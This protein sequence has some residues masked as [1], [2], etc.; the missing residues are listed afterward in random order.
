[1]DCFQGSDFSPEVFGLITEI[2]GEA[3]IVDGQALDVGDAVRLDTMLAVQEASIVVLQSLA[4]DVF[5]LVGERRY[6]IESLEDNDELSVFAESL[7]ADQIEIIKLAALNGEALSKWDELLA[8]N[9]NSAVFKGVRYEFTA[10]QVLPLSSGDTQTQSIKIDW[11]ESDFSEK[12]SFEKSL[13]PLLQF[14]QNT[15]YDDFLNKV[16][17]GSSINLE[18]LLPFNAQLGA[19]LNVNG[20]VMIIDEGDLVAGRVMVDLPMN[21]GMLSVTATITNPGAGV[22]DASSPMEIMVDTIRPDAAINSLGIKTEASHTVEGVG[23]PGSLVS[24]YDAA[25]NF[26][27]TVLVDSNGSWSITIPYPT[28]DGSYG[29]SLISEDPAGN[30][31]EVNQL[32]SFNSE[33]PGTSSQNS[34][35][36]FI[37][38]GDGVL[39]AEEARS[40]S[41]A[42]TL[43][44]SSE[45][46]SFSVSDGINTINVALSEIFIVGG[47]INVEGIDLSSLNDGVLQAKI[48]VID[49][50]GE[51]QSYFDSAE[52]DTEVSGGDGGDNGDSSDGLTIEISDI[53][54]DSGQPGD[55][56]TTD[57][58]LVISGTLSAALQAD[59]FVEVSTDGG[60][61]WNLASLDAQVWSFDDRSNIKGLGEFI[62]IARVV[63]L[64]GNIGA[65]DSQ[66]V[67]IISASEPEP[68][69][70]PDTNNIVIAGI[71][72]DTGT[73]G[74]FR[75]IDTTLSVFGSL[76]KALQDDERIEISLDGN[77]WSEVA[78][79]GTTW[80]YEDVTV[81]DVGTVNYQVRIINDAQ[82]IIATDNQTISV[83]DEADG[84]SG[85]VNRYINFVDGGD[86]FLNQSEIT[87]VTFSGKVDA[88]DVVNSIVVSDIN[89]SRYSINFDDIT[90]TVT[91]SVN[92]S[93]QDLSSL[94]DGPLTVIMNVSDDV[95]RSGDISDTSQKDTDVG[96]GPAPAVTDNS[97]TITAISEDTGTAGDFITTDNTLTVSGTLGAA[98]QADE[99]VQIQLENGD[100]HDVLVTGTAWSFVDT[101]AHVPGSLSYSVRIIDNAQNIGATD[102]Q[103]VSIL[104]PG[105]GPGGSP[106][107]YINFIDGGDHFLNQSEV[108]TVTFTGKL[109]T[110]DTVNSIVITDI[111]NNSHNVN[112]ADISIAA[113]GSFSVN[114]QDLSQLDDGLL[115]VT[116]NL[117]DEVGRSGDV[118]DS[119]EK[120]TDVGGGPVP[121]VSNNSILITGISEDTG[122]AGGLYH[123]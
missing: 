4:G 27:D 13:A 93:A 71:S 69:P 72:D 34:T 94:A 82:S 8:E 29:F 48:T 47:V 98:L 57:T 103:D 75:T 68:D 76:T 56:I 112:L 40:T 25:G 54:D 88:T 50:K 118:N 60:L 45:L 86:Q 100:W 99:K 123:H 38:G 26:I 89:G 33:D 41:F 121:A 21:E 96:G 10:D 59:E 1:M 64:A 28:S 117:S 49:E 53:S 65:V 67:S 106:D 5:F 24:L 109:N 6:V 43:G 19:E 120:D 77:R 102:S 63:D 115:T 20:T 101:S 23:E 111:N 58:S 18:V 7:T 91:G 81:H 90:V 113:D 110:T 16:E 55:F 74:D 37:D 104:D 35:I 79:T 83:L 108:T 46:I 12:S 84:P 95:G 44:A 36:R 11:N 66:R 22:S 116:M 70:T 97:I 92:V 114:A 78:V 17:T 51:E 52:K 2:K 122:I 31:G 105:N 80:Q 42:G 85:G 9:Q 61:N 62:V 15:N 32:V 14:P 3:N 87:A 73:E 30:R 119:S 107:R 39:N